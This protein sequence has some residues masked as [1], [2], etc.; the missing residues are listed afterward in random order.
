MTFLKNVPSTEDYFAPKRKPLQQGGPIPGQEQEQP[1]E[2][3]EHLQ[4]L[5]GEQMQQDPN[6]N[7]QPGMEEQMAAEQQMAGQEGEMNAQQGMVPPVLANIDPQLQQVFMQLPPEVQEQ[8]LSLPPEQ[9]EIAL[10]NVMEQM[11]GGQGG[12]Q[13]MAEQQMAAQQQMAAEQSQV[14]PGVMEQLG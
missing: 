12:E 11:M 6:A 5:I 13:Q 4:Q 10:M 8:I 3:N 7:M 2:S 9:I 14:P 1:N